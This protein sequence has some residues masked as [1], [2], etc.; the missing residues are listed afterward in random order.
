MIGVDLEVVTQERNLRRVAGSRTALLS[1]LM[2]MMCA[3]IPGS[4]RLF[5]GQPL[6]HETRC[7]H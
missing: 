2:P 5:L 3:D 1:I 4:C 7:L 6:S